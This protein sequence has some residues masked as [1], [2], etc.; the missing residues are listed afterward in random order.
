MYR[1][2]PHRADPNLY[3][4]SLFY[5]INYDVES[6]WSLVQRHQGS[7]SPMAGGHY[8]FYIPREYAS[9]LVLAFPLLRRQYHKD[10]YT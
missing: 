2:N 5:N 6:V 3:C 9:I 7:I 4:Y 8:D 1:G 10:L